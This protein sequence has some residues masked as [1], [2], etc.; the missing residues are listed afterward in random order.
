MFIAL[1]L[2]VVFTFVYG[3]AAARLRRAET[4]L[5]P[6]L[7]ILQSVP[8]LG[9]LSITV[10]AF[11]AL[12]PRSVLGLECASIFAI[13]TSQAWNMTFCFYHSLDHAAP[14]A[15]RGGAAVPADEVAAVL[16]ARRAQLDDRRWSGTG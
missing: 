16:E 12:F 10:T 5:I 1:G 15:G 11:I 4:V 7:D 13:F 14:R 6:V 3:T 2:S 9:F 8:I